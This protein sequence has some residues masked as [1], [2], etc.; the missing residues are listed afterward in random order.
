MGLFEKVKE[1][2]HHDKDNENR[3]MT[4]ENNQEKFGLVSNNGKP[5]NNMMDTISNEQ[6][7]KELGLKNNLDLQ[8]NDEVKN[9]NLLTHSISNEQAQE[10]SNGINIER[11]DSSPRNK[12]LDLTSNEEFKNDTASSTPLQKVNSDRLL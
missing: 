5:R 9:K 10:L 8:Y 2:F 7:A 4:T 1:K 11:D 12:L 3:M 6:G